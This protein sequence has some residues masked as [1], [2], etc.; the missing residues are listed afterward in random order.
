MNM[1]PNLHKLKLA[2]AHALPYFDEYKRLR[3]IAINAIVEEIRAPRVAIEEAQAKR[4]RDR[5]DK[6]NPR[7][8]WRL[9]APQFRITLKPIEFPLVEDIHKTTNPFWRNT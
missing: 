2:V 7:F 4:L 6:A 8:L 3:L 5:E 9:A 1:N